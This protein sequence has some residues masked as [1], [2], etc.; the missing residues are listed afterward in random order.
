MLSGV[1]RTVHAAVSEPGDLFEANEQAHRSSELR[2]FVAAFS[3]G[4]ASVLA[5]P[6]LAIEATLAICELFLDADAPPALTRGDIIARLRSAFSPSQIETQISRMYDSGALVL[7]RSHE[8][9][10]RLRM[11]GYLGA[12]FAKRIE[13]AGMIESFWQLLETTSSRLG[14]GK[15]DRAELLND[16]SV[17]R[18]GLVGYAGELESIQEIGTRDEVL[19]ACRVHDRP[20]RSEVIRRLCDEIQR[21]H[22]DLALEGQQLISRGQRYVDAVNGLVTR[23]E[24]DGVTASELFLLDAADYEDAA[25]T[26]SS[27]LLGQFARRLVV[28][29]PV[30]VLDQDR[31]AELLRTEAP[32]PVTTRRR[33]E[34]PPDEDADPLAANR[35]DAHARWQ[36]L[37]DSCERVLQGAASVDV[38]EHLAKLAPPAAMFELTALLAAHLRPDVVYKLDF[39]DGVRVDET[40][41]RLN[42]LS[43]GALSRSAD[44]CTP[45]VRPTPEDA[46]HG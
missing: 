43:S 17:I 1:G 29:R 45:P 20:G 37:V 42:W 12:L 39:R 40:S 14:Y 11:I 8:Q 41:S 9:R 25:R 46:R 38:T 23:L 44:A 30:V 32:T 10:Y 36:R 5:D 18:R 31:M 26:A 21:A 33:P 2:A 7:A 35:V 27:G 16:M 6:A 3:R 15:M 34:S 19:R 28:D 22:P 13:D 24:S 4:P